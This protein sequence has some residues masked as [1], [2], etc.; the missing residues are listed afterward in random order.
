MADV[1]RRG[2]EHEHAWAELTFINFIKFLVMA[3]TVG[4]FSGFIFFAIG[5]YT[6]VYQ[7]FLGALWLFMQNNIPLDIFGFSLLGV[8]IFVLVK[9]NRPK[10]KVPIVIK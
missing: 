6:T 1:D 5:V 4:V 2:E 10:K 3:W 7:G 8:M 9:I